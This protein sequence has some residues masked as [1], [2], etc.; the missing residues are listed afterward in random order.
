MKFNHVEKFKG[1]ILTAQRAGHVTVF[2]CRAEQVMYLFFL[3][4][5]F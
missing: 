4:R 5:K 3:R 2:T 1:S